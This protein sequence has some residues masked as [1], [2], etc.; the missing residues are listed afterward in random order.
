MMIICA[1]RKERI[2]Y[3]NLSIIL[4]RVISPF[5]VSERR[6]NK[7]ITNMCRMRGFDSEEYVGNL[8]GNWGEREIMPRENFGTPIK[9]K[10]EGIEVYGV[11]KPD[12]YLKAL[13]GDYMKLPS[14][15]KR[16]SHHDYLYLDLYKS[17]LD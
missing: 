3:K 17:Y 14:K 15:D 9:Y 4:G 8:V 13:Y 16:V 7:L 1:Y 10:F 5:F 6:I 11:E 12:L 2:W